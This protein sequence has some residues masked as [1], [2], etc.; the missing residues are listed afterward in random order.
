MLVLA[1]I[2]TVNHDTQAP[3]A[4]LKHP[5]SLMLKSRSVIFDQNNRAV[6]LYVVPR[7]AFAVPVP[8]LRQECA[9]ALK[10]IISSLAEA[11]HACSRPTQ[12]CEPQVLIRFAQI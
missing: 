6:R 9:Q 1:L 3:S 5:H 2:W 7:S 12:N 8:S 11:Y 4:F 10:L